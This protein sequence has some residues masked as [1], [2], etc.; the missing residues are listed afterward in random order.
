MITLT[1]LTATHALPEP[2][3]IILMDLAMPTRT[4]DQMLN[5]K[6]I[7]PSKLGMTITRMI[8]HEEIQGLS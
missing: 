6:L 3:L 8:V 5:T 1:C 2:M 4:S 7:S